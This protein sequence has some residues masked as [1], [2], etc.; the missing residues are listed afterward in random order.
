MALLEL[1]LVSVSK[2]I[3]TAKT[4]DGR[5][6]VF[7]YRKHAH[8]LSQL[9]GKQPGHKF[10][11]DVELGNTGRLYLSENMEMA[12]AYF[13]VEMMNKRRTVIDKQIAALEA[14]Y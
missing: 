14:N 3:A 8:I 2:A 9:I 1:E 12:K 7:G 11:Q 4:Q 13:E 10:T 6:V 5:E